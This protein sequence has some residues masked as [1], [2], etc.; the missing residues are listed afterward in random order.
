MV[1]GRPRLL[2]VGRFNMNLLLLLSVPGRGSAFRT[3]SAVVCA[4]VHL[5]LAGF[6]TLKVVNHL[7]LRLER[8]GGY[9]GIWH[10]RTGVCLCVCVCVCEN[11]R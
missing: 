9:G 11:V 6:L 1:R 4:S 7:W 10:F 8:R 5:S 2:S 3:P